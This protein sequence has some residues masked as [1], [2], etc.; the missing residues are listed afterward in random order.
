MLATI[1]KLI[2]SFGTFW[3]DFIVG[4]DVTLAI[5]VVLGLAAVAAL[6]AAKV[7]AWWA[8]PVIWALGLAIS[9]ARVTRKH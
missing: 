5:A 8:L 2:R 4:D 7:A 3:W 6:H 9:L 1:A